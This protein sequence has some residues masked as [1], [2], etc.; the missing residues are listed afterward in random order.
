ML[1]RTIATVVT[2]APTMQSVDELRWTGPTSEFMALSERIDATRMMV[3][4][5]KAMAAR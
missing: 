1:F 3:R 4:L 2:D 5:E